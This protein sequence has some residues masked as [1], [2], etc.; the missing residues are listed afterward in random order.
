[1]HSVTLILQAQ[2]CQLLQIAIGYKDFLIQT[3]KQYKTEMKA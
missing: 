2:S 1:M 3:I